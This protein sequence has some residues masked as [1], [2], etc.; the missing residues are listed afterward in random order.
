MATIRKGKPGPHNSTVSEDGFYYTQ[1][2]EILRAWA[3]INGCSVSNATREYHMKYS[4]VNSFYCV[5]R[6]G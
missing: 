4:G 6:F 5:H 3:D 2:D 1:T